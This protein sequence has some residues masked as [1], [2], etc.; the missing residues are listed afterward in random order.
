MTLPTLPLAQHMTPTQRMFVFFFAFFSVAFRTA[1]FMNFG[2][3]PGP[4][5]RPKSHLGPKKC[6]PGAN[7]LQFLLRTVISCVFRWIW[8]PKTMKNQ[9]F[10]GCDFVPQSVFF[11]TRR[12]LILTDRRG[13][14]EGSATFRKTRFFRKTSQKSC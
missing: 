11:S 1:F 6:V 2:S 3:G 5:N 4:K 14:S 8:S 12:T 10:F 13:T 7:F 9:C